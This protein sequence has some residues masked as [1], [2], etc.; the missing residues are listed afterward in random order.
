MN[1]LKSLLLLSFIFF[2]INLM[3]V[4]QESTPMLTVSYNS[5][6][7]Q[8]TKHKLSNPSPHASLRCQTHVF[9]AITQ[10]YNN[11]KRNLKDNYIEI[12]ICKCGSRKAKIE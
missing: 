2:F 6:T 3:T 7:T 10:Y 12:F 9:F 11:V 4:A 1:R 5:P 8:H